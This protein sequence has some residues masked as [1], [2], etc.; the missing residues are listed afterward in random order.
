MHAPDA[1]EVG[2]LMTLVSPSIPRERTPGSGAQM[3]GSPTTIATIVA[4]HAV[5]RAPCRRGDQAPRHE[6]PR[7]DQEE[8]MGQQP[9]IVHTSNVQ[10]NSGCFSGCGTIF[11]ALLLIGLAVQYWYISAGVAVIGIAAAIWHYRQ[12]Q[13]TAVAVGEETAGPPGQTA[14]A[15]GSR[16][17]EHCGATGVTTAFCAECGHPQTKTCAGC[18]ATGLLSQFCPDCGAATYTPP[19]VA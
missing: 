6:D 18:G 10:K 11:A 1:P 16:V 9:I 13:L 15:P 8:L 4:V 3:I 2:L 7:D 19:T 14:S 5:R 12:R 17:C